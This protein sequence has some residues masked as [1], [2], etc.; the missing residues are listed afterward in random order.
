MMTFFSVMGSA[1]EAADTSL[2]SSTIFLPLPFASAAGCCSQRL[3]ASSHFHRNHRYGRHSRKHKR[4]ILRVFEDKKHLLSHQQ[5]I[6]GIFD[7]R[8][9]A[10][11]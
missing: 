7:A 11:K 1:A 9:A 3:R 2:F 10:S 4:P 6:S 8:L 5:V